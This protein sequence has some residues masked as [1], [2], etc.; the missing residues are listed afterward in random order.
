VRY[1]EIEQVDEAMSTSSPD[2]KIM[3]LRKAEMHRLSG[4]PRF[5]D[6]L[7]E[8]E[9]GVLL[10]DR[11]R[12]YCKTYELIAPFHEG[13]LRP[14]SYVLS[15]GRNY[16]IGGQQGALSDGMPLNI[17]PYQVAII[18]TLETI[19]MPEY[20]IGRWNVQTK[21]AYQGLLWVGGAQVD[22][23]FRGQLCCPI[24]NLSKEAVTLYFRDTLAVIDFVTTTPFQDGQ[25][26]RFPWADRKKLVFPEYGH[27]ESGIEAKV[28][29]FKATIDTNRKEVRDELESSAKFSETSF[30]V[31]QTRIDT[32]LT[33]VFTV[34][35]VLF[36]GLGI[37]ATK[38]TDQQS[39]LSSPI[40]VAGVALYFALWAKASQRN[41]G[42]E[43]RP[44]RDTWLRRLTPAVAVSLVTALMVAAGLLFDSRRP[45]AP[46]GEHPKPAIHDHLKTGQ[47]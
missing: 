1:V 4:L 34:V 2:D 15:V 23:G 10:S 25:C 8:D 21:R 5:P 20:L 16:S 39:W 7:P 27:L 30:R 12:H 17:G 26:L 3:E 45:Q 40:W 44:Q 42:A 33:L 24:Y 31:V 6:H 14:A 38:T 9:S 18:E 41:E 35:A 32:F 43:A 29:E 28:K 36:A 37:V 13:Q 11:I 19:N 46:L 22:P 47:R